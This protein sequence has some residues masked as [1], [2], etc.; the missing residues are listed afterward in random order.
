MANQPKPKKKKL[1]GAKFTSTLSVALVLFVLGLGALAGLSVAGLA[2]VM[3]EHFT[4]TIVTSEAADANYAQQLLKTLEA[5][6]YTAQVSYIS[7]DSALQIV[8]E[9]LGENPEEFLGFNPLQPSIELH[10]KSEY[11]VA[12]S[13]SPI[14][15]ALKKRGGT[16]IES[17]DY[18]VQLLDAINANLHRV[19][20]VLLGLAAV[21][22]LIS[23]SLVGNTV[24]LALHSDRFL[25]GTMRLVGATGW[26]IRR[27]FVL[28]Q[29]R[30]G[31]L[32]S[33]IAMLVLAGLLYAGIDQ[34][35]SA[36]RA[37]VSVILVPERIVVVVVGMMLVGMLIP[38]W[39]AWRA[40]SRY[41]HCATDELYLM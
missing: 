18:N 38:A 35:G 4:I 29:A 22:L 16:R 11:A 6:P 9:E 8:T 3:R 14:V 7:A 40:T 26:F 19:G 23:M 34:S 33:I 31:L 37:L 1:F 41:L 5:A 15:D 39:A 36:F 25:I 2:E 17:I 20:M 13:I 10:L 28:G 24:R 27:P 32:A 30:L 12:D 21:L